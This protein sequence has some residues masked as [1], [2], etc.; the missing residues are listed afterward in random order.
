[1]YDLEQKDI[2]SFIQKELPTEQYQQ[3]EVLGEIYLESNV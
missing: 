1:M 3:K 2:L